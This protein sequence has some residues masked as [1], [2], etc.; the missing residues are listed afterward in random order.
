SFARDREPSMSMS[1]NTP[2]NYHMQPRNPVPPPGPIQ[3]M[4]QRQFQQ[5]QFQSQLTRPQ[6]VVQRERWISPEDQTCNGLIAENERCLENITQAVMQ[7]RTDFSESIAVFNGNLQKLIQITNQMAASLPM[8]YFTP[9]S[10]NLPK[11]KKEDIRHSPAY[12]ADFVKQ[13][14]RRDVL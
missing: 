7:K 14:Q 12:G 3:Q 4:P 9:I 13:E 6:P 5:P 11:F 2:I 8:F 1:S 10:V